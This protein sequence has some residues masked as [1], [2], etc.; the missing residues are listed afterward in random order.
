MPCRPEEESAQDP[1]PPNP[2]MPTDS[3]GNAGAG[4]AD[5]DAINSDDESDLEAP[6]KP[7]RPHTILS[8]EIVQRWV[9]GDRA[10]FT[11]EEIH[12][13][14][15]VE[16]TKL[17][18]LS[19]QRKFPCHKALPTDL[20]GWKLART[21]TDKRGMIFAVYRCPMRHRCRCK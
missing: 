4:H 19:G 12:A 1:E 18:E 20:G 16:A 13:E 3:I 9:N 21:H 10:E 2:V 5:P 11:D 17:M 14:L 6:Q 8:Y 7:K 15:A